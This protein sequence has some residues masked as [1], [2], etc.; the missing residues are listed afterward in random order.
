MHQNK[1]KPPPATWLWQN[2][3]KRPLCEWF[4]LAL[5]LVGHTRAVQ[6][7]EF[8][9]PIRLED[10]DGAG[11]LDLRPP[12][13]KNEPPPTPDSTPPAPVVSPYEIP[14]M[15]GNKRDFHHIP[16]IKLAPSIDADGIF[17]MIVNCF[18]ERPKCVT[19][20]TRKTLVFLVVGISKPVI[21]RVTRRLYSFTEQS[22]RLAF[23]DKNRH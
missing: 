10:S 5:I 18:P 9:S 7:W 12:T 17:K 23:L 15:R 16:P 14:T 20:S 1:A 6:A 8:Q 11:E 4:L 13:I 22:L 21:P 3:G 2:G 19:C